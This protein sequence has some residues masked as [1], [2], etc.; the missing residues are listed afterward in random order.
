MME[1]NGG[2]AALINGVVGQKRT[3][4]EFVEEEDMDFEAIKQQTVEE[5][6]RVAPG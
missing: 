1:N 6:L 5:K 3:H 4:V 2:Q